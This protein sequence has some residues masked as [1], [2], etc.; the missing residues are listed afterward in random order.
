MEGFKFS[1]KLL[2]RAAVG[3]PMGNGSLWFA[4]RSSLERVLR[5]SGEAPLRS[6]GKGCLRDA[7]APLE[8]FGASLSSSRAKVPEYLHSTVVLRFLS[9]RAMDKK[10]GRDGTKY[11]K[12]HSYSTR[13][14]TSPTTSPRSAWR[15][16]TRTPCTSI[17]EG[18]DGLKQRALA[19]A[20]RASE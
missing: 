20:P 17:E 18:V 10:R 7:T 15:P 11:S 2:T 13:L 5:S 9:R 4:L 8:L 12:F 6:D 1:F 19:L 14:T 3:D 16:F